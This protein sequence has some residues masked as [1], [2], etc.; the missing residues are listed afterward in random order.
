MIETK[1]GSMPLK[2]ANGKRD[3]VKFFSKD[4]CNSAC[5]VRIRVGRAHCTIVQAIDGWR[6]GYHG[7]ML[8]HTDKV[9]LCMHRAEKALSD[10]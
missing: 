7:H 4:H 2:E 1:S 5:S 6:E 9:H 8:T 10:R 3:G